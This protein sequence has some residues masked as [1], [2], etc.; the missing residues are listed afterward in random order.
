MSGFTMVTLL[1]LPS[2]APLLP[3]QTEPVFAPSPAEELPESFT[4]VTWNVWHGLDTGEFWVTP[5]ESPEENQARLQHQVAQLAA[6]RP[7]VIFLQEVNP[8]PERALAYVEGLK[9]KGLAYR[10]VHQVDACGI[11]RRGGP[12]LIPGLNNGLVILAKEE[13]QLQK[14]DG[15]KLSGDLGQCESG[16]GYQLEEL[17]YGL[18]AEIT[19]QG[20]TMK[21]LVVS[22]HLHSGFEAGTPFLSQVGALYEQGRFARYPWLQWNIEQ[23]RLRRIGE[24]DVLMRDLY[25][26]SREKQYAGIVIGG[27]FNFESD[28]LE[29]EEAVM[30]RLHD[31]YSSAT[32]T[33][34][35]ST[36]DPLRNAR[37]DPRASLATP[38]ELEREIAG[39]SVEAQE[40]IRAAY[41]TEMARPRRIDYLFVN[42]FFPDHCLRQELFGTGTNAAGFPASDHFGILSRYTRDRS[43]CRQQARPADP[44]SSVAP[45][46]R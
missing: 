9:A 28:F 41:R 10:Q 21:Y 7:D 17:R 6:E 18:L 35:F 20:T 45:G 31:T 38:K 43:P 13:L 32:R 19:V 16:S 37:I 33:G 30:L 8:L 36:A 27:D 29:Y 4:V 25:R 12:G 3:L 22:V 14:L 23:S 11:R 26:R 15:L 46:A 42:G 39:E 40:V 2:C 34:D 24:L 44:A 5:A 1:F